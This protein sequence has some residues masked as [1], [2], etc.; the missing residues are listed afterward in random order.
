MLGGIVIGVLDRVLFFR[1]TETGLVQFVLFLAVLVL[2]AVVS[3]RDTADGASFQFA[4]ASPRF[5]NDCAASG[6]SNDSSVH[7]FL[8]LLAA[9][10]LPLLSD[11]SERH[12]TWT[13]VVAFA[14]CAVSVV[15]L[16]GWG[17]QLSLGQMAFAGLEAAHCAA[18]I[19]GVSANIG[20]HDRIINGSLG[21]ISFLWALLIG[22]RREPRRGPRRRRCAAGARALARDQ[23]PRVRDRCAG[24]S[25]QPALLHAGFSTVQIP[26]RHRTARA[27]AQEPCVLLL[28]AD[29]ARRGADP[30]RAPETNRY[31]AHDRGC[32]RTGLPPRDDRVSGA[33]SS[34]RSR[35]ADSSPGSAVCCSAQ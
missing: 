30:C 24:L 31:R 35:S 33:R 9:V 25:L 17:G 1:S 7:R 14:L 3:R 28:R 34:S 13:V 11:K 16:T 2:V 8:A 21:G 6:G 19:R 22:E 4:P 15:V 20:W 23:H 18:L 12:Q 10:V 5:R 29:R 32:A 27:D 26:C